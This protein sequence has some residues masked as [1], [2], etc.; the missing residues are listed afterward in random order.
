MVVGLFVP[1]G[2]ESSSLCNDHESVWQI[3]EEV[4]ADRMIVI[5]RRNSASRNR[6]ISAEQAKNEFS[7]VLPYFQPMNATHPITIYSPPDQETNSLEIASGVLSFGDSFVI[8]DVMTD[9][10]HGTRR[11]LFTSN[12]KAV[13][14]EIGFHVAGEKKKR[15]VF[16]PRH[17]LFS[18]HQFMAASLLLSPPK[19]QSP[20]ILIL[21]LGGGCLPSFF[22][23]VLPK[24]TVTAI[25][26]DAKIVEV[27]RTF[28]KL[29]KEVKTVVQDGVQ[30]VEEQVEHGG[31][32]DIIMVDIDS[33]DVKSSFSFPPMPFL[34]VLTLCVV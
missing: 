10:R 23:A 21:G 28:F 6:E 30:F 1:L 20:N 33:K 14:S 16:E 13:Q 8:S 12:V 34:T 22:K 3:M 4:H 24:A 15:K 31:S 18:I 9:A 32:F 19:T 26:I 2:S 25:D 7:A 29:P 11:L 17:L 5:S 27:A